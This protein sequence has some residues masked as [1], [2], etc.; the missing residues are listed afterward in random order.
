MKPLAEDVLMEAL[1]S[2]SVS[3]VQ[4]SND[5]VLG[6]RSSLLPRARAVYNAKMEPPEHRQHIQRR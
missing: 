3:N 4:L 2:G 6:L 1:R 5:P